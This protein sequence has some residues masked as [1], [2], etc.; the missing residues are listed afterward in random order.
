M[1]PAGDVPGFDRPAAPASRPLSPSALAEASPALPGDT[2]Y[3]CGR[4]PARQCRVRDAERRLVGEPGD[5]R[6]RLLS[7]RRAGRSPGRCPAIASCVAPGKRPRLTPNPAMALSRGRWVMP[8]GGPGGDLQPQAMLQVF[9]NHTRVRDERAGGGGGP[10]LRHAQ[11]PGELRAASV[12][13][14]PARPRAGNRGS[15]RARRSRPAAT[16]SSGS[17]ISPSGR[18]ASARSR[19]TASGACS[20]AA[21]TRAEPPAPWA[22]KR[23]PTRTGSTRGRLRARRN[24][25]RSSAGFAGAT[26]FWAEARGGRRG[27][28]R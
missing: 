24:S 20:T 19:P 22:G 6:P 4:R 1:P 5:P 3:V 15:A 14:G 12:S 27:P 9:L 11:L 7:R 26:S 21:P 13:P 25:R 8:F 23:P 2:S 16:E 10:A 17:P 18:P 28:L